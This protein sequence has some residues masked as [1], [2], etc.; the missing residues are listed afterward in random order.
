MGNLLSRKGELL[1]Q[2]KYCL[3]KLI[4]GDV[5]E[6]TVKIFVDYSFIFLTESFTEEVVK[7]C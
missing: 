6:P 2:N 1:S 7:S 3:Y 4:L 5:I